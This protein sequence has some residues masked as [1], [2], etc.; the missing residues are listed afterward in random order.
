MRRHFLFSDSDIWL[1]GFKNMACLN[2][3]I[4]HDLDLVV[5]DHLLWLLVVPFLVDIMF[6]LSTLQMGGGFIMEAPVFF[7]CLHLSA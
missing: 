5:F 1:C 4:S 3:E 7:L 6:T 2:V